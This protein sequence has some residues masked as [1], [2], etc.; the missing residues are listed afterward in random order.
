ML[1]N[2]L[3]MENSLL[4]PHKIKHRMTICC[5]NFTCNYKP[6]RDEIWDSVTCACMYVEALLA[7]KRLKQLA[8]PLKDE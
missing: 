2:A 7:A 5:S 8:C 4:I 1:I 6:Q 3:E